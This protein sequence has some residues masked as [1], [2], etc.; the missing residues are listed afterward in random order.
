MNPYT[1][2]TMIKDPTA[3]VGRTAELHDVYT[4][5]AALQSCSIVGPRRIGK[6]SLLYH[7]THP[8]AYQSQIT[9]SQNY[10]FAFID[11]QELT[12]FGPEDFFYTAV[13]RLVRAGHGR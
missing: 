5:L 12:G 10:I 13:E 6:S 1:S 9:Q 3:F 7:L 8:A 2:R 4:L 11:L